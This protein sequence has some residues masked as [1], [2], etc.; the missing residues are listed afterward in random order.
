M[1]PESACGDAFHCEDSGGCIDQR[2]VC[3]FHTDCPLGEDEGII[4][5]EPPP[6]LFINKIIEYRKEQK[7]HLKVN[8]ASLSMSGI[9]TVKVSLV[10]LSRYDDEYFF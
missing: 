6:L 5:G 1:K 8:W 2:Q 9:F 10:S 4:C 7:E 3:N